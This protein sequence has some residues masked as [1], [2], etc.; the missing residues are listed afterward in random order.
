[1]KSK[2]FKKFFLLFLFSLFFVCSIISELDKQPNNNNVNM[3]Q[4]IEEIGE[5]NNLKY[6][7]SWTLPYIN[8]TNWSTTNKTY[9]WCN[10]ENGYYI[11]ENVTITGV[12]GKNGILIVNTTEN[13]IIRN[14]QISE[15]ISLLKVSNG[16]FINNNIS[17]GQAYLTGTTKKIGIYM[18]LC[19]NSTIEYN[20]I[21]GM[22]YEYCCAIMFYICNN[23]IINENTLYRNDYLDD[24]PLIGLEIQA[25]E[26]IKASNNTIYNYDYGVRAS[27]GNNYIIS[28]N[29]IFSNFYGI[30]ITQSYLCEINKNKITNSK[31]GIGVG[32]SNYTIS[33]N[34]IKNS[35]E[36]GMHARVSY[37]TFSNN[38]IHDY[39]DYGFYFEESN[40][41][42]ISNNS[43]QDSE[44]CGIYLKSS[45]H[46]SITGNFIT[47]KTSCIKEINCYG[48][49]FSHNICQK[50]P[51]PIF[52]FNIWM[53]L[54]ILIT[55][56]SIIAKKVRHFIKKEI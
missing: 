46:S 15:G 52:G 26:K 31:W 11:I 18:G 36:Y 43:I 2:K 4:K 44:K 29:T 19:L 34:T 9:D 33:N 1:M 8:I 39:N 49:I 17:V 10:Y 40:Y 53:M 22:N 37:S 55:I 35:N 20:I 42:I 32:G 48:N 27:Q 21:N 5:F 38:F 3:P 16:H 6:L 51:E 14:C 28:N 13:F 41:N 7:S 30:D 24:M 45:N 56:T 25:S 50:I 47:Y 54:G 12:T 23:I